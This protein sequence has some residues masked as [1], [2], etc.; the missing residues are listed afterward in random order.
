MTLG[1]QKCTHIETNV[2]EDMTEK[3]REGQ[4]LREY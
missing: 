3:Q 2:M 4:R 1:Y